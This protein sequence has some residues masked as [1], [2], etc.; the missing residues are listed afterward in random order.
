LSDPT[1][2]DVGPNVEIGETK[3]LSRRL[4]VSVHPTRIDQK[5]ICMMDPIGNSIASYC[6][7]NRC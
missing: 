4:V 6:S 3:Q 1:E 5:V 2:G 7:H